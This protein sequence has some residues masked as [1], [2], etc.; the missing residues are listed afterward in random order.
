MTRSRT[1]APRGGLA[2][3]AVAATLALAGAARAQVGFGQPGMGGPTLGGSTSPSPKS[4]PAGPET[5]A[6]SGA[7]DDKIQTQEATLPEDPSAL[8]DELRAKIGTDAERDVEQGRGTKTQRRFYGL[9]YSE[10]SGSYRFRTAFPVWAQRD[11]P[12]DRATV[13]PPLMYYNRRSPEVSADVFFPLFWRYRVGTDQSTIVGPF[14][15]RRS[16][17]TPATKTE[18]AVPGRQDNWLAPLW[19]QG[20]KTDGSGYFH[21]PP[22]L[23]FT[24][25]TAGSGFNLAGTAFCSWKGGPACDL[26][27]V[28]KVDLGV[29]PLYFY[30]RDDR[31]EYEVIPPLLRYY[32]Y[33]DVDDASL[34]LWGPFMR[35]HSR[36]SDSFNI[37]PLFY[38][39]WGKNYAKTTVAPLFHYGYEGN[40]R[41]LA[42]PLFVWARGE[43][44]ERTFATWVYARYRGRTE[45]D[46]WTPLLWRYRDPDIGLSRDLF[47]PFYYRNTSPRSRDL[48]IFPFFAHFKRPAISEKLWITPLFRHETDLTGWE[49]DIFPFFYAGR[50]NR[51][52]H[53]VVA[54]ILWDFASPRSRTTV[55]VPVYFRSADQTSVSE[56]VLN[57]YYHERKAVGGKEWELHFFPFFS[58]GETPQGHWWNV[59][60]GLAGFTREGTASKMRTLYIPITLSK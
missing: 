29:A 26:R 14:L 37:L 27:T 59:L 2:L 23:T 24:T 56:L 36:E 57:T 3:A 41:L 22:L 45:L 18:P 33:K 25:H 16:T 28:D 1:L 17:P 43:K 49:T 31:S 19:F 7:G 52:S 39:S 13:I 50:E 51:S 40:S 15:H 34:S 35:T 58:Y 6:A 44:D 48:A 47:F 38:R 42:T 54:P 60:Y 20:T 53:L 4:Q 32:H 11:Q 30:G 21:V 46:M 55:I 10:E 9:Y 12:G 8:P 5:H